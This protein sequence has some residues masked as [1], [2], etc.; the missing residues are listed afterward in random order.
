M[1]GMSNGIFKMAYTAYQGKSTIQEIN[2]FL[3]Y[4]HGMI[5]NDGTGYHTRPH[6]GPHQ[7]SYAF[8]PPTRRGFMLLVIESVLMHPPFV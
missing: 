7:K 4:L 2:R 8:I 5:A 6:R 1:L 3:Y